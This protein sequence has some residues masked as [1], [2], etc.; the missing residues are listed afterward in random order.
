M[1]VVIKLDVVVVITLNVVVVITLDV[2][3]VI[4]MVVVVAVGKGDGWLMLLLSL[5]HDQLSVADHDVL[6]AS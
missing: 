5:G 2:V 4:I 1:V 3:V 6:S